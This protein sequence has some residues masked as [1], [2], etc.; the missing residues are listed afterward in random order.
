MVK[1]HL[2]KIT[3]LVFALFLA[4]DAFGQIHGG[5]NGLS[6]DAAFQ[7]AV[8][9]CSIAVSPIPD[10]PAQDAAFAACLA[11]AG[12]TPDGSL[13]TNDGGN[14]AEEDPKG[15]KPIESWKIK[16]SRA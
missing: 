3:L 14:R 5:H 8:T 9:Q 2:V 16:E 11:Q 15:K 12:S 6:S 13:L 4:P 1:K 10:K 7:Q